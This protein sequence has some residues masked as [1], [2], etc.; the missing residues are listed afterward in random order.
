M[1]YEPKVSVVLTCYNH[2]EYV[3]EA[4]ES[5]LN[6]T[7]KNIE[8][9]VG[10][11]GSTDNSFE[12]I[13]RYNDKIKKIVRLE[14]ND[15]FAC[16]K[17][18]SY[19]VT[20]DLCAIMTSDDYWEPEKISLQVEAFENHPEIIVC[21][22]GAVSCDDE[23]N[24]IPGEKSF[25]M[26]NMDRY[27]RFVSLLENGNCLAYPSS[28][29][30]YDGYMDI[31][32]NYKRGYRQLGDLF[33]WLNL[34]QK[35]DFYI[36]PQI[37]FK[38]RN[39]LKGKNRNESATS[40]ETVSRHC[41]EWTDIVHYIIENVDD[42]YF[43]KAIEKNAIDCETKDHGEVLC[44]KLLWMM[45]HEG[46]AIFENA[47]KRFFHNNF[48]DIIIPLQSKYGLKYMD[49]HKWAGE[50]GYYKDTQRSRLTERIL[51]QKAKLIDG[52]CDLMRENGCVT[53][54]DCFYL[55]PENKQELTLEIA[56]QCKVIVSLP[57]TGLD[58]TTYSDIM[59]ILKSI[60]EN[61]NLLWEDLMLLGWNISHDDWK[62]FGELIDFAQNEMI[63]LNESVYPFL[64]LV[65]NNLKIF[66]K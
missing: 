9:I 15:M 23:L 43:M 40:P 31:I 44:E 47:A 33:L 25:D 5:V 53:P 14:K 35:G 60:H 64:S 12:V 62:L 54:R 17:L 46:N 18:L 48:F 30:K 4:I 1:S 36:V 6:Q 66:E 7:Y 11:N 65:Y 56:R 24:I 19:E 37:L 3:G 29:L 22:T 58:W 63:D 27:S 8:L 20:G 2:A 50:R 41:E 39:H 51:S 49:Y 10:D 26:T 32:K 61:V 28:M 13:S 42:S 59:A 55:L 45:R 52:I 21:F 38:F 34:T 16:G 57:G